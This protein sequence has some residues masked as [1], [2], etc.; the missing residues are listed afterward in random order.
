MDQAPPSSKQKQIEIDLV[1]AALIAQVHR[2]FDENAEYVELRAGLKRVS[3]IKD[4]LE[5]GSNAR[6]CVGLIAKIIGVTLCAKS[7]REA[8]RI[9]QARRLEFEADQTYNQLPRDWKW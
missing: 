5:I 2:A 3:R 7:A 6:E 1:R 9:A 4:S 8:G